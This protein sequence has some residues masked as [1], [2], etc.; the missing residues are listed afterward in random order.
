MNHLDEKIL[1][2]IKQEIKTLYESK[3]ITGIRLIVPGAQDAELQAAAQASYDCYYLVVSSASRGL[4]ESQFESHTARLETAMVNLM[5]RA[6]VTKLT[7]QEVSDLEEQLNQL[8]E[9]VAQEVVNH[10]NQRSLEL[11]EEFRAEYA[12][13]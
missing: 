9:R 6:G 4:D 11:M 10:A 12:N 2:Q 13:D 1:P 8:S 7:A 5:H 3:M